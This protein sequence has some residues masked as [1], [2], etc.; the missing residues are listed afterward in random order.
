MGYSVN[1]SMDNVR[2]AEEHYKAAIVVCKSLIEEFRYGT[3]TDAS[4]F[5][6]LDKDNLVVML[7]A[8]RFSDAKAWD[9]EVDLGDYWEIEKWHEEDEEVLKK[10]APFI[11]DEGV[12]EVLGEDG[13]IWRYLFQDNAVGRQESFR[14]W[15]EEILL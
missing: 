10:L 8:L 15:G 13:D 4:C 3:L 9:S 7:H 11:S 5:Y 14:T 12:V 6:T 1:I 2:I